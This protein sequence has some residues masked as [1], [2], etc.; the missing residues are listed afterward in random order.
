MIDP[1]LENS[2]N[3]KIAIVKMNEDES[4]RYRGVNR[5]HKDEVVPFRGDN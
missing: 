3:G 5:E 1:K 2:K 4:G